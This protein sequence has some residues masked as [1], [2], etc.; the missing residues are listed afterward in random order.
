M[1]TSLFIALVPGVSTPLPGAV[2]P[3]SALLPS[4]VTGL[5]PADYKAKLKSAG[6][7]PAKL[8][9]LY[10]WTLED[11]ER[12]KYRKRTLKA[13]IKADPAHIEAR[14]AL[15]H[16][17][18]EGKWFET[19]SALD[20]HMKKIAEERGLVKFG[21]GWVPSADVPFLRRGLE[22]D[23]FGD[24]KDPQEAK[25]L[26]EG[27]KRQDLNW[28]EPDDFGKMEEGLWKCGD[29]WK[30]LEDANEWHDDFD[31]PWKIPTQRAV[32]WATTSRETAL[33]AAKQAELAWFDMQK[34]F[35][36]ETGLP[37]AFFVVKN[38][39]EYLRFMDGDPEY[40]VPQVDPIGVSAHSRAAFADLWIDREA[41]EYNGMGV[42][43]WDAEDPNGSSYGIHDARFAYGLSF[44]ES[45]D[46]AYD[47]VSDALADEDMGREEFINARYGAKRMPRWFQ[48]GAANYASRWFK[49]QTVKTGGNPRWAIEWSAS[50]LSTQGGLADL[51]EVFEFNVGLEQEY[52]ASIIMSAGLLVAYMVDGANPDL[53]R[54]LTKLQGEL[55]KGADVEKTFDEIRKKLA[56]NEEQIRAFAGL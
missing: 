27:W 55:Q 17:E 8:W 12:K 3:S 45:L 40:E 24:W 31:A 15:G 37:V 25:R 29:H 4:L 56:E 49:D 52:S 32:V 38:Q 39:A 26:A 22:K 33:L 47:A 21:K 23:E 53:S 19:E 41:G 2:I 5:A 34:V 6:K 20:K 18:F 7:D 42:T 48:W 10:Q 11:D 14:T 36:F 54:L 13:V 44:V 28:V 46:P 1:L 16:I 51:D 35:G 43:Y 50:N 30:T 9:E